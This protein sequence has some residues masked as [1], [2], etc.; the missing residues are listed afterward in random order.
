MRTLQEKLNRVTLFST[1]CPDCGTIHPE[2]E[3]DYTGKLTIEE[4]EAYA[5]EITRCSHCGF[6]IF[7]EKK[8]ELT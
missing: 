8:R 1:Q 6:D 5:R 4:R 3:L 7:E 2:K